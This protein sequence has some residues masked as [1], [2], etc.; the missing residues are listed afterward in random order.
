MP[1]ISLIKNGI[2]GYALLTMAVIINIISIFL[3]TKVT[4]SLLLGFL[5]TSVLVAP[6]IEEFGRTY[7]PIS[8]TV[9]I[10]IIELVDKLSIGKVSFIILIMILMASIL[11]IVLGI[12][13][14]NNPNTYKKR[15]LIHSVYNF[16]VMMISILLFR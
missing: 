9:W 5:I 16:T 11:H 6:I 3:I 1:N 8:F 14:N 10:V 13:A 4:S 12:I 15:I 7:Y 2:M